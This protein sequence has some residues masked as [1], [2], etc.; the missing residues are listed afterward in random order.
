MHYGKINVNLLRK[1]KLFIRYT[2]TPKE[3]K[4]DFLFFQGSILKSGVKFATPNCSL[5]DM[6]LKIL[7]KA[8]RSKANALWEIKC[9]TCSENINCL[10]APT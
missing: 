10:F 2:H 1:Q 5:C 6:H 4:V 3:G 8:N 7:V 9:N